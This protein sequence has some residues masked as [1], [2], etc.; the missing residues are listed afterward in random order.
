MKRSL[1][2]ATTI[3]SHIKYHLQY[4]DEIFAGTSVPYF[5]RVFAFD[6]FY[7]D[8]QSHILRY[9]SQH[10]DGNVQSVPTSTG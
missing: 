8:G 2:R 1:I 5:A 7:F 6:R 3:Y 9:A 10:A 4:N